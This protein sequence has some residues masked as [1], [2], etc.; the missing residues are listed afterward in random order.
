MPLWVAATL[1]ASVLIGYVGGDVVFFLGMQ[2]LGVTRAHTLSMV[3]PLMSAVAG[4]VLFGEV[5][6]ATRAAGS[7]WWWAGSPSS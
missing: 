2:Q 7:C 3:H 4:I 5:M 6:T 1:W